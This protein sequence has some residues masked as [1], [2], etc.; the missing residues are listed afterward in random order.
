MRCKVGLFSRYVSPAVVVFDGSNGDEINVGISSRSGTVT[1]TG[2]GHTTSRVFRLN[3][4]SGGAAFDA[5]GTGALI[6]TQPFTYTAGA[7]TL[8]LT[9]TNT[10]NNQIAAIDDTSNGALSLVKTGPGL[11]TLTANST[12]SGSSSILDGTIVVGV[13]TEQ[14]SGA[15]GL[16]GGIT[17][18]TI[19]PVGNDANNVSGTAALLLSQGVKFTKYLKVP[20]AGTN[21]TQRVILGGANTSGESSFDSSNS[22]IL[23]GRDVTLQAATGGVVRFENTWNEITGFS[24]TLTTNIAVGTAGNLGEVLLTNDLSTTGTV[25][26]N[27]GRLHVMS[28]LAAGSG[29]ILSGSTAELQYNGQSPLL[30]PLTLTEGTLSGT[31]EIATAVSVGADAILS[32]GNPVGAQAFSAGVTFA[33]GGTYRVQI[34][35]WDGAAGTG[36]DQ[37]QVSG[38]D[39]SVT[40]T[41]GDKFT[42]QL[43]G[44][45]AGNV[46]GA[47]PNFDNTAVATFTIATSGTLDGFDANKFAID[48]SEFVDN[49]DLDGGTWSLSA[50]GDDIVLTFTPA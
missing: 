30:S 33:S 43:V 48:D 36:Y 11:W 5:S 13:D 40:A 7:K 8:T 35:D 14:N 20:A 26:V 9:G 27:F 25:A 24:T 34:N 45:T 42:I 12:Y 39:L 16:R 10:A 47:V 19:M 31:A 37:L 17:P 28:S 23:V 29:V 49:N 46:P 21:S 50:S 4:T 38:D 18:E 41:S 32:P 15:F 3:G 1:Y 44:L 2:S 6:L 22:F